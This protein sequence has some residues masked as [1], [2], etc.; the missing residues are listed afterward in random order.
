MT[1][2]GVIETPYLYQLKSK[3]KL[4]AIVVDVCHEQQLRSI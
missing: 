4:T 1:P 3:I 2:S